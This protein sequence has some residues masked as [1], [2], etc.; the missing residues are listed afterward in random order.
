MNYESHT[1]EELIERITELESDLDYWVEL[2][3][4]AAN[5]VLVLLGERDD[6]KYEL[7][8]ANEELGWAKAHLSAMERIANDG[9]AAM[10]ELERLKNND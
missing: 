5:S 10:A 6:A 9:Y 1:R 3:K 7:R 4:K 8:K 2:W